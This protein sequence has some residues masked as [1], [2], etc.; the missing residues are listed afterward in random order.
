MTVF[1]SYFSKNNTLID[2]VLS[3][4][5]QNPVTEITYGT[6]NQ[7]VSRFIFDINFDL[8]RQRIL[9]GNINPQTMTKHVLHLTNTIRYAPEYVGKRSYSLNIERASSF[10]LNLFNISEEW[11]EGSGYDFTYNDTPDFVY[12]DEVH[13][14][15]N[16][17]ASNWYY[18]KTNIPWTVS[19]GSYISGTTTIF[20]TQHFEKGNEDIEIDITNYVNGKLGISGLTGFTGTSYG[21][22]LKFP[23]DLEELETLYRQAVGFHVKNTHT[24]YEPYI[25]TTIDNEIIDD[26]NYFYLDKDNSLFLY[27]NVGNSPRNVTINSV[28]IYDHQDQLVQTLTGNSITNV[29]NGV[30]K[31]MLNIGSDEYPDA[32]L[33]KDVWN[34]TIDGREKQF[35]NQFYLISNEKYYTFDLSNEIDFDNYSFYFWGINQK[36]NIVA[37]DI[38]KIRLTIKE[39]YPNQD[40]FIPLDVEY[41]LYTKIGEKYE[42][43]VIPFTSVNRT[44]K[45]YEID[46]DTGWLIPQDYCL[47]LRLKN[48]T[49]YENKECVKFTVI[50]NEIKK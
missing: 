31:I 42:L 12:V 21:L 43:D 6:V 48:G 44:S 28:E 36:E 16:Q 20:G 17:Q 24:F 4:N 7:Q 23:D 46:L 19:G 15:P 37:G 33:F 3:N 40:S 49:Y 29:K 2:G 9:E 18:R 39:L 38:R 13:Q 14:S 10:D 41:R 47:E 5:S 35:E 11:D 27:V 34:V 22:G 45:G 26:R 1:R 30:Y 50:S 32:I 25:E 8:L